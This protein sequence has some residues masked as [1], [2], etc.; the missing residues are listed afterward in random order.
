[1]V[2]QCV[3]F[4]WFIFIV[5]CFYLSL[6]THTE[7]ASTIEC[8]PQETYFDK[9]MALPKI[10]E[11]NDWHRRATGRENEDLRRLAPA[12]FCHFPMMQVY[13]HWCP[14]AHAE[15]DLVYGVPTFRARPR[16]AGGPFRSAGPNYCI[17]EFTDE[18]RANFDRFKH[19]NEFD[20]CVFIRQV[21]VLITRYVDPVFYI[22]IHPTIAAGLMWELSIS[23]YFSAYH[24]RGNVLA[25]YFVH[26]SPINTIQ[27]FP[28]S[29]DRTSKNDKEAFIQRFYQLYYAAVFWQNQID[30]Q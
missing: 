5:V 2:K 13:P 29:L 30:V 18:A 9:F 15:L 8:D 19:S 22:R 14:D 7:S 24:A 3:V 4:T 20:I 21:N 1:M 28:I 11:N 23:G 10:I 17:Y 16:E 27:S 25:I 12:Y 6:Q 26:C